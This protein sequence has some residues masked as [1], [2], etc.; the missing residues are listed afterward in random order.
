MNIKTFHF[1][2]FLLYVPQAVKQKWQND[3]VYIQKQH[4]ALQRTLCATSRSLLFTYLFVMG[5]S[6]NPPAARKYTHT[7]NVCY[8]WS[9]ND[10]MF[11]VNGKY[12]SQ[13]T[14]TKRSKAKRSHQFIKWIFPSIFTYSVS[15]CYRNLCMRDVLISLCFLHNI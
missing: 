11:Y 15:E 6:R 4:Q 5:M 10:K 13:H 14:E 3:I 8:W 9:D 7:K 1:F 12:F 2:F